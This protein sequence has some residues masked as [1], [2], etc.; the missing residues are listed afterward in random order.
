[1]ESLKLVDEVRFVLLITFVAYKCVHT[2]AFDT[3]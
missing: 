2:F 1:M 3:V